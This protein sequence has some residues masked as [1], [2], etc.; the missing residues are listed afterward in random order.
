MEWIGV[1]TRLLTGN[2]RVRE[3]DKIDSKSFEVNTIRPTH[4]Q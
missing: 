1:V 4:A 2:E 3:R